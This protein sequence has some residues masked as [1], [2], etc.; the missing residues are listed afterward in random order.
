MRSPDFLIIGAMK[1]GTTTLFEDLAT[2]PRVFFPEDKEPGSLASDD[3]LSESGRRRYAHLFRAA[4]ADQHCGEASTAYTKAPDVTGCPM[5]AASINPDLKLVYLVREPVSRTLSQ[6]HHEVGMREIRDDV[7]TAVHRYPRL[8]AYSCYAMQLRAWLEVFDRSQIMVVR[9]EDYVSDRPRWATEISHFLGVPPST[10]K[11]EESRRF[12]VSSDKPIPVGPMAR[13]LQSKV[14][15]GGVRQLLHRNVRRRLASLLLPRNPEF[16]APP[17]LATVDYILERVA[18]DS[19]E[20]RRLLGV[21]APLWDAERIRSDFA[22]V[23]STN[24]A[25]GS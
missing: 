21:D 4:G 20:L 22:R 7:D 16:V 2:N 5:R 23:L 19:Q 13:V 3:V 8:I 17:S 18:E 12:N 24:D 14:Y 6:H 1:A 15:R 25:T 11:I 9:F 10:S